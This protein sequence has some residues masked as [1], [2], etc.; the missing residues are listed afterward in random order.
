MLQRVTLK[1]IRGTQIKVTCIGVSY[2]HVIPFYYS[3]GYA[4]QL[5]VFHD[6][7]QFYFSN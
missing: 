6:D 4:L 2:L 3:S 5:P 7:S 1:M